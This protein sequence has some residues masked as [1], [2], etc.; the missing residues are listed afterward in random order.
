M[1][2]LQPAPTYAEVV[3]MD[4]VTKKARFSPIWLKWFL[5]LTSIIN[6]AGGTSLAHNDLTGIQGGGA[7]ERF[8][9]TSAQH[10]LVTAIAGSVWTPTLTNVLNLDASTAFQGQYIRAGNSVF[11]ACR[12]DVD[13]TAAGAVQLGISLPVASNIGAIEDVAGVAFASGIAGQGAAIRG[14]AANDRA[15]LV[16]IAVDVTNQP[17]YAVFGYQVI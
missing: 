15:E 6:D 10:S 3:I 13:P 2:T 9:L 12:V 4:E 5:D 1:A 16:Y 14:D 8:H 7:G 17:M 11:A